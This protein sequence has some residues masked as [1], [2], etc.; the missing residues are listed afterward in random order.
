MCVQYNSFV[1]KNERDKYHVN[2]IIFI[3]VLW[4]NID[5]YYYCDDSIVDKNKQCYCLNL[6]VDH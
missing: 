6:R 2:N 1:R 4:C 3:Y 5:I